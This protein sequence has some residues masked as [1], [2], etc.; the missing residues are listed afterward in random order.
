MLRAPERERLREPPRL[1]APVL[2]RSFFDKKI[3]AGSGAVLLASGR[4]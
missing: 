1:P 4:T 3:G 2:I